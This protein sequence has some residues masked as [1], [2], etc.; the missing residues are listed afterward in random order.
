[1]ATTFVKYSEVDAQK[2]SCGNPEEKTV[3]N[4]P[5]KYNQLVLNYNY[6]TEEEPRIDNLYIQLPAVKSTGIQEQPG[7]EGRVAYSMYV[8]LPLG[9]PSIKG[10]VTK[11]QDCYKRIADLLET[12]KGF[13]KMPK[14]KASDP[15]GTN[16]KNPIYWPLDSSSGE[17]IKGKNPSMYLKLIKRGSGMYEEKT[18]FTDLR[19]NPIDWK[20][21]YNVDMLMVPLVQLEK[22]YISG[23][24]A[25]LQVKLVS[26][27]VKE[28]HAR[29]TVTRQQSTID[30][31]LSSEP[32]AAMKLEQQI[33]QLLSDRSDFLSGGMSVPKIAQTP[34]VN[35]TSPTQ[36]TPRTEAPSASLNNFLKAHVSSDQEGDD[37]GSAP[38]PAQS[39]TPVPS[40]GKFPSIAGMPKIAFNLS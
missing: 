19:G 1:M 30:E 17:V 23:G 28:V 4:Q 39:F 11:F 7:V 16:F 5:A 25:S 31:I 27:V 14:F 3:P 10:F 40:G 22:L 34:A 18:L 6:G 13:V 32:D 37:T 9:D 38:A 36:P 8:P 12:V 33:N 20:L 26:V 21:L 2:I 29:G 35:Q 15:E 24:K